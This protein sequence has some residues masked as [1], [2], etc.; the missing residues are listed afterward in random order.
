MRISKDTAAVK[1]GADHVLIFLNNTFA[2]GVNF[3]AFICF[4]KNELTWTAELLVNFWL[5]EDRQ[6]S[7][8]VLGHLN[9]KN[10]S[11]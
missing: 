7:Y 5:I 10:S 1:N 2:F 9:K 4:I 3:N 11:H 6:K 8:G